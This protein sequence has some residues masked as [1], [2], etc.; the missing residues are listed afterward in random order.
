MFYQL[1]LSLVLCVTSP[2]MNQEDSQWEMSI[3]TYPDNLNFGD[4]VYIMIT[5]KNRTDKPQK[6]MI[7]DTEV[8]SHTN[9]GIKM[10]IS[11]MDDVLRYPVL[12]ETDSSAIADKIRGQ[13]ILS[14]SDE[15]VVYY[16]RLQ[17]PPLEDIDT[18][19]WKNVLAST[20]N[21]ESTE[22]YLN[23]Q[24]QLETPKNQT[25]PIAVTVRKKFKIKQR[26]E[27]EMKL[28]RTWYAESPEEIFPVTTRTRKYGKGNNGHPVYLMDR[29]IQVQDKQLH[30]YYFISWADRTPPQSF[31]PETWQGWQE[32]EE[33]ISEST[34]RDGIRL[35]RILIQ[36]CGTEDEK[37]LQELKEWFADMSEVQRAV[38]VK[39]MK[40]RRRSFGYWVPQVH[41]FDPDNH[42][43]NTIQEY[44][45]TAKWETELE[46]LQRNRQMLLDMELS[47]KR[48]YLK[49]LWFSK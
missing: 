39:S 2:V 6:I 45:I 43:M 35:T 9:Y 33:S 23:C 31:C 18:E 10:T 17:F 1:F 27:R 48:E 40:E 26:D 21:G 19:F 49:D 12:F 11:D 37:V 46:W 14:P 28:L 42:L 13:G 34:M 25:N 8:Y 22:L 3:D 4:H 7:F 30:P 38:M 47:E 44:D 5:L 29:F 16:E 36:Y 15:I 20:N 41:M 24:C 32:L